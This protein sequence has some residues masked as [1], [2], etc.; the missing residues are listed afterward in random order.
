MSVSA[1]LIASAAVYG[2]HFEVANDQGANHSLMIQQAAIDG[3]PLADNSEI[4]VFTPNG[5]CAGATVIDGDAPYGFPVWG[6][7]PASEEID[8]FLSNEPFS[9]KLW[10]ADAETEYE[11]H[12]AYTRGPR[13][14]NVN[15]Q[16]RIRSVFWYTDPIPVIQTPTDSYNFGLV[17]VEY[18]CEW[19]LTI[20]N[21]GFGPLTIEGIDVDDDAFETDFDGEVVIEEEVSYDFT[22]TFTP[23]DESEFTATLVIHS[24]DPEN[25]DVEI[26]LVGLGTN[27]IEPN[28]SLSEPEYDFGEWP[29]SLTADWILRITNDGTDS[30]TISDIDIDN[31]VFSYDWDGD[32]FKIA[33]RSTFRLHVFFDPEDEEEYSAE[34]TIVSDDPDDNELIVP[35]SGMGTEWEFHFFHPGRQETSHIL[36]ILET[37]LNGEFLNVGDEI[38]A[39]TPAGHCGGMEEIGE[40]D[41][42]GGMFGIAAWNDNPNTEFVE[43]FRVDEQIYFRLWDMS[44]GVEVNAV[45]ER[46]EGPTIWTPD[47]FTALNLSGTREPASA[48]SVFPQVIDYGEVP[49]NRTSE[50]RI[51]INNNGENGSELRVT[52]ITL[53]D[54][55]FFDVDFN[56]GFVLQAEESRVLTVTFDPDTVEDYATDLHILSDSPVNSE[57]IIPL[58][59]S[60][61]APPQTVE[62]N[63][64]EHD[65]GNVQVD[66]TVAW[67]LIITNTGWS[68]LRLDSIGIA[69]DAYTYDFEGPVVLERDEQITVTVS[70]APDQEG[71]FDTILTIFSNDP[72]NDVF[73]V[74]LLGNGV[75]NPAIDVDPVDLDFGTITAGN[76]LAL[77]FTISNFGTGNLTVDGISI[78]GQGF[79]VNFDTEFYLAPDENRVIPVYFA[80]GA[81]QNYNAEAVITSNDP[82]N[83][84]VRVDLSGTGEIPP[85][86]ITL[87]YVVDEEYDLE[88]EIQDID[89]DEIG[90]KRGVRAVD[91]DNDGDIDVIG[92]HGT[93]ISW[94][95][96]D[97]NQDFTQHLINDDVNRAYWVNFADVDLDGDIDILSAADASEDDGVTWWENDGD[98]DFDEH[99]I[100]SGFDSESISAV[101]ID[102]DYDIDVV[103]TDYDGDRVLWWENDGLGDFTRHIVTENW[104]RPRM[105]LP[106]DLDE[107]GDMDFVA[108]ATGE[109]Q[110]AWFRND[111]NQNFTRLNV[112]NLSG[113]EAIA[114]ADVDSDGDLDLIGAAGAADEVAWFENDG[115]E[116]FSSHSLI[117]DFDNARSVWSADF[118]DDGDIDIVACQRANQYVVWLENDG[119]E[120]FSLNDISQGITGYF[121]SPFTVDLDSD[122]DSD[123]LISNF[124]DRISWWEN[125]FQIEHDF[126]QV[127]T[128]NSNQWSFVINNVGN[129]ILRITNV[130]LDPDD[131]VYITDFDG[132]I[133]L[134]PAETAE[135]TVTFQPEEEGVFDCT[136]N[137]VSNDPDAGTITVS[138]TGEGVGPNDPPEVV[139]PIEDMELPEDFDPFVVANLNT[140]FEDPE[141][142]DMTFSIATDD[143]N[144]TA[145]IVNDTLLQFDSAQD[146]SGAVTVTVT[147]DDGVAR[148]E[149]GLTVRQ[150][151]VVIRDRDGMSENAA[152]DVDSELETDQPH[153]DG[154]TDHEVNVTVTPVNDPPQ[155]TDVPDDI[156]VDEGALVEFSV[157]GEDIDNDPDELSISQGIPNGANFTDNG[158]GTGDFSW[159]TTNDDQGN[160]I[161][162]LILSDGELT[163]TARVQITVG[164]VNRPPVWDDIP[165]QVEANEAERIQ[166][167]VTGHDPDDDDVTI[168]TVS[169]DLPDGWGY[170]DNDDGTADFDWQ[171]DYTHAGEYSI[172]FAISDQEYSVNHEIAIIVNNVNRAPVLEEI[173][174]LE[175]DEN[176]ELRVVLSATDPDDNGLTYSID[177]E[178]P[179]GASLETNVFTW[180]PDYNQA[181]N[182]NLTFRVTDDEEGQELSDFEVVTITVNN[183]N[184]MPQWDEVPEAIVVDEG[185][186]IQFTLRGSDPDDDNLTIYYS[187]GNLPDEAWFNDNGDGTANFDWQTTLDDAGD[188][189]AGFRLSDGDADTMVTVEIEVWNANQRPVWDEIPDAIQVEEMEEVSFNF[190]GSDPDY[191]DLTITYRSDDLPDNVDFVDN[192]DGTG[193]FSWQT[194]NEDEG[195]YTAYFTI[196]DGELSS[197]EDVIITV[198]NV[199]RAP[200]WDDPPQVIQVEEGDLVQFNL[201][202]SDPDG[203]DVTV[204]FDPDGLPDDYDYNHDG[205]GNVTF[206][207]QTGFDDGGI[208]RPVFTISDGADSTDA[209]VIIQVGDVNREPFWTELPETAEVD[210]GSELEFDMAGEDPDGDDLTFGFDPDDLPNGPELTDH[211]DNTA[212]FNWTPTYDDSNVYEVTFIVSDGDSLVEREV[213]ITVNHVNLAPEWVDYPTETVE[214]D[215]GNELTFT[216]EGEDYDGDEL[217][218]E[219]SSDDLPQQLFTD[220]GEG[221]GSFTWQT[222]FEDAGD[223]TA[224][225]T[226][227]DTEY[228]VSIDVQISV[229]DVNRAPQWITF[230]DSIQVDENT[231]SQFMVVGDDPDNDSLTVEYDSND[232][233]EEAGFVDN[234]DGS[235]VFTWET[236]YESNGQYTATF[237]ISDGQIRVNRD[238][239]ITVDNLNRAP[240]FDNIPEDPHA[241]EPGDLIEF[242]IGASDPD[243]DDLTIFYTSDDIPEAARF[244]DHHD[245]SGTFTWQTDEDDEGSYTATFTV[246]DEDLG[247]IHEVIITVGAVNRP[248]RWDFVPDD[249]VVDEE[250]LIRFTLRASDP[251]NEVPVITF[252]EVGWPFVA[253]FT[254]NEDGTADFEWQ[255][256]LDDAG[257]YT[258]TFI[259]SDEEF[260]VPAPL[261]IT[262]NDVNEAPEW[263][264]VPENVVAVEEDLI[265]FQVRGTDANDDILTISYASDDLPEEAE[266]RNLGGGRGLFSWQTEVGDEGDYSALFTL[267]DGEFDVDTLVA[268][269]VT[270]SNRPPVLDEIGDRETSEGEEL[271]ITLDANDPDND[272]LTFSVEGFPNGSTLEDNV[273]TWTPDY[274]QA[275]DYDVT[276]RVT[277]DGNPRLSV[278]E[279]ITITVNNTNRAPTWSNPIETAEADETDLLRFTL[280]GRDPDDDEV[281]LSMTSDD[282]PD[283]AQFTDNDDGTGDFNWQTTYDDA[284]VYTA[285]F[286]I[287]DNDLASQTEVE[288]TIN[289]VN[290]EPVWEDYPVDTEVDED[291]LIEFTLIG[292]DPD[293]EEVAI[294]LG[295]H[296]LPEGYM[297]AFEGDGEATFSWR[298]TYDDAG[299]Y[300][301]SF[302]LSD[303]FDDVEIEI[304]ITVYHVNREPL[305][306]DVPD[307]ITADENEFI[308]FVLH[309][310]DPDDDDLTI[311]FNRNNLPDEAQFTDVGD[312]VGIFAWRTTYDDA[313]DYVASFTLSDGEF[314]VDLNLD[315]TVNDINRTPVW[316]YVPRQVVGYENTTVEFPVLASDPEGGDLTITYQS[317]DLPDDVFD[318]NGDG[319]GDFSWSTN[320]TDAGNYT[321]SFTVSDGELEAYADVPVR[322]MDVNRPP[323]WTN[324]PVNV[325]GNEGEPI[326]FDVTGVDPD[327]DDVTLSLDLED[328]PEGIEFYDNNDGT[329]SF[330]W[331]PTYDDAGQY[332][333]TFTIS[334]DTYDVDTRVLVRVNDINRAPEWIEAPR[335]IRWNEGE[336]LEFDLIG[337]DADG[338]DLTITMTSEELPDEAQLFNVDNGHS[339]FSWDVSYDDAGVYEV[340]FTLF[341][342]GDA[343]DTDLTITVNDINRPPEWIDPPETWGVAEGSLMSLTLVGVDYDG[344]DL[345]IDYHSDDIPDNARFTDHGDGTCTLRWQTTFA[346]SG[347]YTAVFTLSDGDFVVRAEVEIQV[348]D[349]NEPPVWIDVPEAV[350]VNEGV[351]IR[352]DV[353]A[354]DPEDADLDLSFSSPDIDE[355]TV[356][357]VD[358]GDGTGTFTWQTT[359]EDEG[360][361][362]AIFTAHDDLYDVPIM[363]PITI[364]DVNRSPIWDDDVPAI[365]RASEGDLIEFTIEGIDPDGDELTIVH[366][367]HFLPE[368][369]EFNDNGDGSGDFSW[370]TNYEDAGDN[371]VLFLRLSDGHYN[372]DRQIGIVVAGENRPLVWVD[373]PDDQQVDEDELLTFSIAA[374]DPDGDEITLEMI[375]DEAGDAEFVDNGDGTGDFSWRARY[376]DDGEFTITFRASDGEDEIE[377]DITI[378][379][380]DLNQPP[381]WLERPDNLT[382]TGYV[383]NDIYV[384][385]WA[386]DPDGVD[387]MDIQWE[388]IGE[389]PADPQIFYENDDV[390]TYFGIS[391]NRFEFGVYHIRVFASDGEFEIELQL[392]FEVLVD[393]FVYE[394]TRYGHE[395]R[396]ESLDHFGDMI[397]RDEPVEHDEIGV[398]TPDGVVAGAF[399]FGEDIEM[400]LNL[401]AW[402][403]D[404]N[405]ETVEGFLNGEEFRFLF[406]DWNAGEEYEMSFGF[407]AGDEV[408]RRNGFSIVTLSVGPE[409]AFDPESLDFGYVS[410]VIDD[411]GDSVFTDITLRNVGT[412]PIEGL[413][414][415]VEGEGFLIDRR[416]IDINVN[417]E[418]SI[419]VYFAPQ[420]HGLHEGRLRAM[421]DDVE[422]AS[423]ELTG[424]GIEMDYFQYTITPT[425]HRIDVLQTRIADLLA[426]TLDMHGRPLE[427]GE[428]IGVFTPDTLCAGAVIVTEE[429]PYQILAFGDDP[430]TQEI[431]GFTEDEEFHFIFYNSA[432]DNQEIVAN[433]TYLA[434]G[435]TWQED[436]YSA[437]SLSSLVLHYNPIMTD[438]WHILN[439]LSVDLFGEDISE[440]D[441]I[442]A[443]TPQG[444]V[445][446]SW[447][448]LPPENP[449]SITFL[450]YGDD[451]ETAN[452]IEGFRDGENIYFRI[453]D[454][455][456]QEEY[457]ARAEWIAGP[458]RW[459]EDANSTLRLTAVEDNSAPAFEPVDDIAVNEGEEIDVVLTATD[460]D[461]DPIT[462]SLLNMN[463]PGVTFNDAGNGRGVFN[464]TPAADQSGRYTAIFRAYDGIDETL[465]HVPI[466]VR[467]RNLPPELAE[468]GALEVDEGERLTIILEAVD[469]EGGDMVF[470][471]DN[472]PFGATL[473]GPI[474]RWTPNYNQAGEYEVT[475]R[476][477]DFGI[478]PMQD[479]ELVTITVIDVN[480]PPVW[481][482]IDPITVYEGASIWQYVYAEDPD[483]D[484]NLN[485]DSFNLPEG[486]EF[487]PDEENWV[488]I[489]DTDYESAGHYT[490]SFI[491]I[492]END[493]ADTLTID[494]TVM[495]TNRMPTLDRIDNQQVR[496]GNSVEFEVN[497]HDMDPDDED[498]LGLTVSNPPPGLTISDIDGPNWLV[499]WEPY[500]HGVFSTVRFRVTDPYRGWVDQGVVFTAL[501]SDDVPPVI[502]DLDPANEE[503]VLFSRPAIRANITDDGSGVETVE[504]IF[505]DEAIENLT[506]NDRIG[507]LV[508]IPQEDLEDGAH[509]YTVR[510]VDFADNAA[511]A[512]VVFEINTDPGVIDVD[513]EFIYTIYD[514]IDISGRTEPFREL[515]LWRGGEELRSIDSDYRGRFT[516]RQVPLE[517]E[518][519][520]FIIRNSG[521]LLEPVEVEVYLDIQPPSFEL[522]QPGQFS[523]DP[524]PRLRANI[525]DAGV[526]VDSEDGIYLAIDGDEIEDFGFQNGV[527]TYNVQD[528]LEDGEHAISLIAVDLLGNAPDDS[529]E[530]MFFIDSEPPDI[531]H[532]FFIAPTDTINNRQPELNIAIYDPLPSSGIVGYDIILMVDNEELDYD[533]YDIENA[534][535]Y[536]FEWHDPLDTGLHTIVIDVYDRAQN[537][538]RSSG[539]FYIDDVDDEDP[540]EFSNLSPPPFSAAGDGSDGLLLER[541]SAD[542]VSFVISD[543][544]AGVNWNSIRFWV[545]SLND[546]DDDDDN[547]TTEY[548]LGDM[549]VNRETGMVIIPI[550][551]PDDNFDRMPGD[552]GRFLD[553]GIIQLEAFG[554][555]R[556]SNEGSEQWRF[557]FDNTQ[558]DAPVLDELNEYYF[559]TA[560]IGIS[561]ST[562]ADE[563]EYEEGYSNIS[564]VRMYRNGDLVA[565]VYAG[566]EADFDVP[567]VLLAEGENTI[568]ATVVDGGGN[569]SEMSDPVELYLDL[570]E[571]EIS[572]L[573]TP[574]GP[575][576]SD[577]T[578]DFNAILRDQGSGIDQDRIAF[579]ID[580][581]QIE[582][583]YDDQ[584]G[585]FTASAENNLEEGSYT[586]RL[587]VPDLAGNETVSI[588]QFEIILPAVEAPD[589]ILTPY[590]SVNRISL[591]GSAESE[592]EIVVFLNNRAIG[593][594]EADQDGEFSFVYNAHELPDTSY[595]ELIAVSADSVESDTT[596]TQMLLIDTDPPLFS[597]AEPTNGI[598]VAARDLQTVRVLVNDQAAGLDPDGFSLSL[599]G[600]AFD[601]DTAET[602]SGYWLNADVSEVEFSHNESVQ[603]TA[604]ARDSAVTPNQGRLNWR[605]VTS[606]GSAP[607]VFV[608]D[609]SFNEDEEFALNL[610][611]FISDEDHSWQDLDLSAELVEN[612]DHADLNLN[613]EGVMR[614]VSE[615]NWFGRL[616]IAVEAVDPDDQTGVDTA[617]VNVLPVNDSPVFEEVENA[618]AFEDNWFELLVTAQDV[619][620]DDE[621]TFSDNTDLFNIRPG[622]LILFRPT[623]AMVGVYE[624]ELLVTDEAG[625]RDQTSFLLQIEAV[626]H[627]IEIIGNIEDV[628]MQEDTSAVE[629]ADLDDIFHDPDADQWLSF[630]SETRPDESLIIAIEPGSN[631]LTIAPASDFYGEVQVTITADDRA[632]S[633]A[634]VRFIVTVHGTNDPPRQISDD[635]ELEFSLDEDAGRQVI[636]DLDS[637]FV[638][639]DDDELF[640]STEGGD[641]LGAEIDDRNILSLTPETDW[642][643]EDTF[644]LIVDDAWE[645][646]DGPVRDYS[647]SSHANAGMWLFANG[648]PG[649]DD[650]ITLEFTVEVIGFNDPPRI[651]DPIEDQVF[652]EDSGPWQVVNL[653][654]VFTE[655][656]GEN[657]L[658]SAVAQEPLVANVL[659]NDVLLV[660]APENFYGSDFELV[661]TA[662]DEIGLT[663][664][665]TFYV[666]IMSVNDA[667]RVMEE[668]DDQVLDED[669]G[670]WVIADLDEV[671]EDVDGDQLR[672]E[673]DISIIRNAELI[674]WEIN[675][676]NEFIIS[677]PENFNIGYVSV[678]I[679]ADDGWRSSPVSSLN[680]ERQI[681]SVNRDTGPVRLLRSVTETKEA[682]AFSY[683]GLNSFKTDIGRDDQ[684]SETFLLTIMA[685]NDRPLWIDAVGDIESVER[686]EI[687]FTLEADDP[688]MEYEGDRLVLRVIEENGLFDRGAEF[689]DNGDG[690]GRFI[691]TPGSD[692]QGEYYAIFQVMDRVGAAVTRT[693]NL[694]IENFNQQLINDIHL[695][696]Q[697]FVEDEHER[698]IADLNDHF[699]DPDGDPI[700]YSVRDTEGIITRLTGNALLF[701]RPEA[702]WHGLA[703][704]IVTATD[705]M[706]AL[707][708]DTLDVVVTPANDLPSDFELKTPADSAF[709]NSYPLVQFNWQESVDVIED[710]T[711]TYE[712]SLQYDDSIHVFADLTETK[713]FI[714]RTTFV[715]NPYK[716]TL[717]K[718]WIIAS[719]GTDTV[720]CL[721]TYTVTIASIKKQIYVEPLVPER[722]DLRDIY[723]NPFNK[724]V[725]I[726]YD[727]PAA[728]DVNI[729]VFDNSGR[730][731]RLIVD[732]YIPAGSHLAFWDGYTHDGRRAS[733][734]LYIVRMRTSLGTK[735]QKV[736]LLR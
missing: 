385:L 43:G 317:D 623:R 559:N 301:V 182:Y 421:L 364:S 315:I 630:T 333:L 215:E 511:S 514:Q 155:W 407:T 526:G 199:N 668:I 72:V 513:D 701:I 131:G 311:D 193:S 173:G 707:V 582:F 641:H 424:Y 689:I 500:R 440:D 711:V 617:Y 598:I 468:I 183:V 297:F 168:D 720:R 506:F 77:R 703:R 730:L 723:P 676:A 576:I 384:T 235:G 207:W 708:H 125:Q 226:L 65:F 324:V 662:E 400:P 132:Q 444:L 590:T 573:E 113:A 547:D 6:D 187:Q 685:V 56:V 690:T 677:V 339:V 698:F 716:P 262:V 87:R 404:P 472:M 175:T 448:L 41:D 310:S 268:I 601:F 300:L 330:Y 346:D 161:V 371:Y 495:N 84:E 616:S 436:G 618:E 550:Q 257:N 403:D 124:A 702:N 171:T 504:L 649:R 202:G 651:V 664:N 545:I 58:S 574:R 635:L 388:Y 151:R 597:H 397:E 733:S 451:P 586:A 279:T 362:T 110:F 719:D 596:E 489:W 647:V 340:T 653:L 452:I 428:E 481:D 218:I 244:V 148:D 393:H 512:S 724:V 54:E 128:D 669:S 256:D 338:D 655:V 59:G 323:D 383:D 102:N 227:S 431:D 389:Q 678:T 141:G 285:T 467:D 299:D 178:L 186:R 725:N 163:D 103:A 461:D 583:D 98:Q 541:I 108:A 332:L 37:T 179:E 624:V 445:A 52:N 523:N 312:G 580:D 705:E 53:D 462:L 25:G 298:P 35:L 697:Q 229:A 492:D 112:S 116:N 422:L 443:V 418:V 30:L 460:A 50:A 280:I 101:D 258:L 713:R 198:G 429:S 609:T 579:T 709:V 94:W 480:Q 111:G 223:Y 387:V 534:L 322:I 192:E 695:S 411:P 446:G 556:E 377:N 263:T 337:E 390:F 96:N 554:E 578:P 309:G 353:E 681:R 520:S 591:I 219:F 613:D 154:S 336:M 722:M 667:P 474:F 522:T 210:E 380:N 107:D 438:R 548:D 237:T 417:E 370:Q 517:E 153:R 260:N 254:D 351:V 269:T 274:N 544:D 117:E 692:D 158:N 657:L 455:S 233:P 402:G 465:L 18:P 287:S 352:V 530:V 566:Y 276:F 83:G 70:F 17:G 211:G 430:E 327:G 680:L 637:V 118:D 281:T 246:S 585:A 671:F 499:N 610:F 539:R 22:V 321:A 19:V 38:G 646:R 230:P 658:F 40:N 600:E 372:I 316:V 561:G 61:T 252:S 11:A 568:E 735:K 519:N 93:N 476:I 247:D 283:E 736:M 589:F 68:D 357:F 483:G 286:T 706:S 119:E 464:W 715:I 8:G 26:A 491:A 34:L 498:G 42:P 363:V 51:T 64:T 181:G 97:G 166:F 459:E 290:R 176:A 469:P 308:S 345:S 625:A 200:D 675:D 572:G 45:W 488:F 318:D 75:V 343:V 170:T 213:E 672:F 515:E 531:D 673:A 44:A 251:D 334:D 47:A 470:S 423:A 216:V 319:S 33:P 130:T 273:F 63:E 408:W 32:E 629:I 225:F 10:D 599:R 376:F 435:N 426:D 185:A 344:D 328:L 191:D 29:I 453:W 659:G 479:E 439:V 66:D 127:L 214:V 142:D 485:Y 79:N 82:E 140:V 85:Q 159:Q 152:L 449:D 224:T 391:P 608:P 92:A 642:F 20:E 201:S 575:Y 129:Q 433:A 81:G 645:Q 447:K 123:I 611:Q 278:E 728:A 420:Q 509:T 374:A 232:L 493:A 349:V 164:D 139:D 699:I 104:R 360:G 255:T 652:D 335:Q 73:E 533:W 392:T 503:V 507:V 195:V 245:G 3:E 696:D 734:G 410:T 369:A 86:D 490:P 69:N 535:Y 626:N 604:T 194:T 150:L 378:I 49:V 307:S 243:R 282:L 382:I 203:D 712:L 478:P 60:G 348:G 270:P 406:W 486:S 615:E 326:E 552:M 682:A 693:I 275:G 450:A 441:D 643:G 157:A 508:W 714:P 99:S 292:S 648:S 569:E 560:E 606:V 62:V 619:D 277:D 305:W 16:T 304:A 415:V 471:A 621:L 80:P 379:V 721:K 341:D 296:N 289:N 458:N 614:I 654:D 640:Y 156:A 5:V 594:T 475:F 638:D 565:E 375:D 138:L 91:L 528:D 76:V 419:E 409:V 267:S 516:F 405:T 386:H 105:V 650:I 291:Q 236:D 264:I 109:N 731:I 510:A 240:Y 114:I 188:Y 208:Y 329:G 665:D 620:P 342:G 527:L 368:E 209:E 293:G 313:G 165:D 496:V 71:N 115:S 133:N 633:Q 356:E 592:N 190:N 253:E 106:I 23:D 67:D 137:I 628:E 518:L 463:L 261:R 414:P 595:V 206:S 162:T 288:I 169:T 28:I 521:G 497:A 1:L 691:W 587:I 145:E 729:G 401:T 684:I 555:D 694:S 265:E 540:P 295:R 542:T 217:T 354:R 683:N 27:D 536:N 197:E 100:E 314:D 284:G 704:V 359:Y 593:L 160:H 584:N 631:L 231:L 482:E 432:A 249:M 228:D 325:V 563:P 31:D 350:R 271:V 134:D 78:I 221:L 177:E 416:Q 546:P 524:T 454:S 367:S 361:Y 167:T 365:V 57:I 358:Y 484:E 639:P 437:V 505:D 135:I 48:I 718:W 557:F 174:D 661:V 373:A 529:L 259:V 634:D 396:I 581:Q 553:E 220:L 413:L 632:G 74:T 674:D 717:V 487:V 303:E 605:F 302:I 622:G 14:W 13:V 442:A 136:L 146:W 46:I 558:P 294:N 477:T 189:S 686:Q 726:P 381:V 205:E 687:E 2:Q 602:D 666:D 564:T 24:D 456:A 55:D 538:I 399:R 727:L 196:W 4:G 502:T 355:E 241:E 248:P 700:V 636:A 184:R 180:T 656:D 147:A 121:I 15:G 607:V 732:G 612:A 120:N 143:T 663:T 90:D 457:A 603:V 89:T 644:T 466:L 427:P 577:L 562:G 36:L 242:D 570:T 494:I 95:E 670:P 425:A 525:V 266:F 9:F 12:A 679:I 331:E 306:T 144:F 398:L 320:F 688:D 239:E 126:G 532:P 627:A 660:T 212:T 172:V 549:I 394:D 551:P 710:S 21:V 222:D 571:P 473:A 238:L 395:I 122:G 88:F 234:G 537:R 543:Q 149:N 39:F 588:Y 204:T 366:Q 567:E 412:I 434:G 501:T 347:S 272:G 7:D 250:D